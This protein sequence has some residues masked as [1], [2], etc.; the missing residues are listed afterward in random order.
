VETGDCCQGLG[1]SC[2]IYV[3][4]VG[5]GRGVLLGEVPT[6]FPFAFVVFVGDEICLLN[7]F[8]RIGRGNAFSE[9]L[10]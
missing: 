6:F 1:C 4:N 7:F 8:N 3:V 2:F 9:M 5:F 10:S